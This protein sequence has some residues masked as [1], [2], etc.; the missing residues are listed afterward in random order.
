MKTKKAPLILCLILCLLL[1]GCGGKTN[2][3][4]NVSDDASAAEQTDTAE[5]IAT[6][7]TDT[8]DDALAEPVLEWCDLYNP[9]GFDT[10]TG[11][12]TNPNSVPIDVT[13]DLVYYKNGAEVARSEDFANFNILPGHKSVIWANYDIP[14]ADEADDIKMENITVTKAY[15]TP[16]DGTWEYVGTTDAVAFFD[17]TLEAKPTLASV[18][19][20][21]YND[22][23]GNGECGKGEIVVVSSGSFME[24]TGRVSFDTDVFDYTDYEVI[25]SAY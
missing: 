12:I 4:T 23:D 16:I 2:P 5:P 13:Y 3:P 1:A 15:N 20:L 25:F 7:A 18:T 22:L 11:V 6:D 21:L 24:Q 8:S 9:N 17:F 14:K 19:F 10:V